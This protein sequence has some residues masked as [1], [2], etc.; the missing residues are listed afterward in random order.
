MTIFTTV[1]AVELLIGVVVPIGILTSQRTIRDNMIICH[2]R[3]RRVI[4]VISLFHTFAMSTARV[5]DDLFFTSISY[6]VIHKDFIEFNTIITIQQAIVDGRSEPMQEGVR[7]DLVIFVDVTKFGESNKDTIEEFLHEFLVPLNHTFNSFTSQSTVDTHTIAA[8]ESI[9]EIGP[10]YICGTL[11][12]IPV[13]GRSLKTE[14][15][16]TNSSTSIPTGGL[17]HNTKL[18]YP[19]GCCDICVFTI[20]C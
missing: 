18:T 13:L 5:E 4:R 2:T 12:V 6:E 14:A 7:H 17:S 19:L 1:L 8:A 16:H 11:T 20:E 3:G 9:P 15:G 10:T